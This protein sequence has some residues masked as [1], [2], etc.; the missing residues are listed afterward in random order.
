MHEKLTRSWKTPFTARNKSC[1]CS[2]LTTVDGG[3]ALGY[4]GIPCV[5]WSVAMQLCPTAASTL[6]G[7]P[8]LP[9]RACK[10]SSGLTGSAYR[11]CGEAASA[12]HAMTLLQVHQ[13]K[14]LRDLHEGGHNLAVLHELRAATDLALRAM[15]VTAQ[16][17][18]LCDVHACSPGAPPLAV[19]H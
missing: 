10:Y 17:L 4:T 6:R 13:A 11:A 18:D 8:C 3:A 14:A 19:S 2:P 7:K 9:S 15:K 16:Y 12:L 5:E 1:D